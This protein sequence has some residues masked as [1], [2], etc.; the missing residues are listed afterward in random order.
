ML[1]LLASAFDR[2]LGLPTCAAGLATAAIMLWQRRE[3]PRSLLRGISWSVLPLVAGLFVLVEG[4]AQ[5]GLVGDLGVRLQA[6]ATS[7]VPNASWA[8][9]ILSAL[10][11]NVMNN[12]PVGLIAGSIDTPQLPP[13]IAGALL[14]GVDLGPNLSVTGSLATILWLAAIRREGETVA[15]WRFLRLGLLVMPPAL[16]ASIGTLLLIGRN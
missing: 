1:L 12:L 13:P 4:V 7:S 10:A 6:A 8:A 5:T 9:G 2:Q 11:C 3:S 16:L 14:I 15:A